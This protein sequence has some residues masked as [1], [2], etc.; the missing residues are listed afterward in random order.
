VILYIS[1]TLKDAEGRCSSLGVDVSGCVIARAGALGAK[2]CVSIVS[3]KV[4]GPLA[5]LGDGGLAVARVGGEISVISRR[6]IGLEELVEVDVICF[7]ETGES[8]GGV[9]V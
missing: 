9:G 3:A 2:S 5:F 7:G 4:T 6:V 8:V 1:S